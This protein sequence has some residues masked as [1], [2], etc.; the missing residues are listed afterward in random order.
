[1]EIITFKASFY[2]SFIQILYLKF[3]CF[4]DRFFEDQIDK[5]GIHFVPQNSSIGIEF[6]ITSRIWSQ[7][8]KLHIPVLQHLVMPFYWLVVCVMT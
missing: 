7:D 4:V 8:R 5:F 2:L 6:Y 1:M 3:V